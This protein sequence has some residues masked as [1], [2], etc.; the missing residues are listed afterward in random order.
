MTLDEEKLENVVNFCFLG[1]IVPS[2]ERDM[3]VGAKR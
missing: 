3:L 2:T 1:S